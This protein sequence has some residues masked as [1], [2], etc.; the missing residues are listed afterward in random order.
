[1]FASRQNSALRSLSFSLGAHGHIGSYST[2]LWGSF[3][4]DTFSC[5]PPLPTEEWSTVPFLVAERSTHNPTN[6][7]CRHVAPSSVRIQSP[8]T[9]RPAPRAPHC[10]V[11]SRA[12]RE[13]RPATGA[14]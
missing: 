14:R 11:C 6:A 8:A 13:Q 3:S 4:V 7:I 10:Q 12:T 5:V 2:A 9:P 1:M